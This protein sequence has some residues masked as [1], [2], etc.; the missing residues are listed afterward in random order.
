MF[1]R[2]ATTTIASIG[3]AGSIAVGAAVAVA[4]PGVSY[5]GSGGTTVMSGTVRSVTTT[6]AGKREKILTN[7]AG[8]PL[9]YYA[10]DS[11]TRSR[12]SGSLAAIWPPVTAKRTPTAPGLSGTLTLV[13]DSHGKQVA[14]NGHLLYTFVGDRRGVVT[15]QGVNG[16]FVATP[17]LARLVAHSPQPSTP[18]VYGSGGY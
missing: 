16:F 6:V 11:A 4:S 5:A 14:Y 15:G 7:A 18:P 10:H 2:R 9:Y 12:V 3:I 13:R 17:G 8:L 1:Q